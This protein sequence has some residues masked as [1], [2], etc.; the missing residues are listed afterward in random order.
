MF[1]RQCSLAAEHTLSK[2]EVVGSIPAIGFLIF[3][4]SIFYEPLFENST[5]RQFFNIISP[6]SDVYEIGK[7]LGSGSFGQV[8]V[9]TCK[10]TGAIRAVKIVEADDSDGEWSRQVVFV[11]E[12]GLL[13]QLEHENIVKFYDFFEDPEFYY[14]VM[15][16]HSGGELFQKILEVKRFS[17]V[18]AGFLG[19]QMLLALEYIHS[20]RIVHRDVKAENF[21]FAGRTGSGQMGMISFPHL[22]KSRGRF[23][24]G[25]FRVMDVV[26]VASYVSSKVPAASTVLRHELRV[27]NRDIKS[28]TATGS[29]GVLS[30]DW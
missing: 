5:V 14:I 19:F 9:A 11:R 22:D 6:A 8:R 23:G 15:S 12:V 2:R 3:T 13:Q 4:S 7:L 18:D 27:D 25:E 29:G 17:E 26:T 1:K 20:L 16:F 24:G 21:L 28:L 10:Q 30:E